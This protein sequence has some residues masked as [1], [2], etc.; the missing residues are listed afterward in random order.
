MGGARL[1]AYTPIAASGANGSVLHYGHAGEPNERR[2]GDGDM[3]LLDFGCEVRAR[4][5]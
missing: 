2:I 5:R 1:T 3:C 4:A